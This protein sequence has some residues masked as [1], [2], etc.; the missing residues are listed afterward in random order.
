MIDKDDNYSDSEIVTVE[1]QL[2]IKWKRGVPGAREHAM[3]EIHPFQH[4]GGG[5]VDFGCWEVE[6][7]PLGEV[8]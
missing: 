1:V 3:G 2:Q 7:L 8:I 5:H 4:K 6:T